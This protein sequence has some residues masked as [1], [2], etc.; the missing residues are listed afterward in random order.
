PGSS[1]PGAQIDPTDSNGFGWAADPAGK[2]FGGFVTTSL[3]DV[4]MADHRFVERWWAETD[5]SSVQNLAASDLDGQFHDFE[6]N[7]A[8]DTRVLTITYQKDAQ[9]TLTW[10]RVVPASDEALAMIVS[11][12]TGAAKNLQQFKL[13]SFDY[14]QAATVNVA[15]V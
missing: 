11:A 9:S 12:S 7:Y 15:Y 14:Q 5:Q 2:W 8:G 13:T 6:V 1:L 3:K 4:E 10:Q